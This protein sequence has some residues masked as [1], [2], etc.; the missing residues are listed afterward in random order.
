MATDAPSSKTGSASSRLGQL[1]GDD[2]VEQLGA[3]GLGGTPLGDA[4]VPGGVRLGAA[5]EGRA[6]VGQD[7]VGDLEGL[8]G[9]EAEDALGGRD[10][11]RAEGGPVGG[12]GVLRVRGRPGDD[13]AHRDDRGSLGLVLCGP[14]RGVQGVYVDVAVL[15]WFDA[16]D[17]P[18]VGLVALEHVLGEGRRGVALDGDV[19]V[20]VEEDEVAEL[21][22]AGERG[23][24]GGDALLEVAV[25]DD[26]PDHV[27]EG[28]RCPRGRPGRRGRARN[29]RPWPCRPRWRRPG[30]AVP[31]W[32]P[33]PRCARTRGARGLRAVGAERLQI[34]EFQLYPDRKS[35]V[36][37][38]SEVWP[39]ERTKRSRPVHSGSA[40]S[41]RITF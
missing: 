12:L 32:S 1:T 29:G 22:V 10:L 13:R 4:L 8:L 35:C 18:A 9:V 38:V 27:I 40:G 16:L 31:W 25:G 21:L 41:C 26:R 36:Y 5:V 7:L 24:L 23:R 28:E 11:V 20:V 15:A 30:R 19:V 3:L 33:R 39:G 17:V 34:I 37:R 14:E 2:A 6:G